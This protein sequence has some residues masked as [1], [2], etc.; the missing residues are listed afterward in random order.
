MAA[1]PTHSIRR[2]LMARLAAPLAL[3]T[4][5]AGG[6]AYGVAQHFSD[7]VLDQ[8]LYDAA[9]SLANR[10]QW[11]NG[12]PTVDL[13]Q[14]AREI[15]E[16]DNV[17][18][19]FYEVLAGDGKRIAGNAVLPPL[20]RALEGGSP[21]I[22][23]GAVDGRPVHLLALTR[24]E[25]DGVTVIVKVAETQQK[26]EALAQQVLAISLVMCF[27]LAAVSAALIWYGI[28]RG[29]G[30]IEAAVRQA[31]TRK[32]TARLLPIAV[33]ADMPEEV[34]PLIEE[35]NLL[36]E[37]LA[38]AHQVTE[39]FLVNAAH[40]LRTP[41][42]TLRVKLEAASREQDRSRRDTLVAEAVDGVTHMSRML[43]QL[44]TL[45][46][47]T[48]EARLP[49]RE[50]ATDLERLA[51]DEVERR[52]DDAMTAGID[53][54]YEGPGAPVMVDAS[55]DLLREALVNLIDNALLYGGGG[56]TVTVGV[57]AGPA[58]EL[59]VED[60]GPGIPAWER[61]HVFDRFYRIPGSR[62]EGCGLGLSIVDEIARLSGATLELAPGSLG[63]GLRA[64]I[65]FA[66]PATG[67][68]RLTAA[69]PLSAAAPATPA[70]ASAP[71]GSGSAAG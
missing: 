8:W 11:N 60:R 69:L 4:V 15:L 12:R 39:R 34:V 71:A 5:L 21:I 13:P 22:Y 20:P 47:A 59:F 25:P 41:V 17:D 45:A 7:V 40:Q 54:G 62:G 43:H 50:G 19:V 2:A 53:L 31:R 38:T 18:R 9:I 30:S 29:I 24:T 26:R 70:R 46:R 63:L 14:G 3:L 42:A 6:A 28:G 67:Q 49:T 37:E 64:T 65:R 55:P 68:P 32:G 16:W 33:G 52:I 27:A 1:A 51:R 58:P 36:V 61:R 57:R 48:E 56:G 35:I 10:V 44:L 66:A 23:E